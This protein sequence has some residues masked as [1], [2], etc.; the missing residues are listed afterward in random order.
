MRTNAGL[1]RGVR[2]RSSAAASGP[3]F[4]QL[5]QR[6]RDLLERRL[7]VVL[8]MAGEGPRSRR[9]G[10]T[11]KP[12][13]SSLRRNRASSISCRS[14]C[15]A[16]LSPRTAAFA[17]ASST[18]HGRIHRRAAASL[19]ACRDSRTSTNRSTA[20]ARPRLSLKSI[21]PALKFCRPF[22]S[23]I[24]I[25][26]VKGEIALQESHAR[27][28]SDFA[29]AHGVPIVFARHALDDRALAKPRPRAHREK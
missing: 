7:L 27:H 23:G 29:V 26:D 15:M 28:E 24:V 6:L 4:D 17:A 5:E 2:S 21:R 11:A 8:R 1:K 10:R 13:S 20:R 18:S 16:Y 3:L 12:C 19:S 25:D 9:S 14:M 22:R